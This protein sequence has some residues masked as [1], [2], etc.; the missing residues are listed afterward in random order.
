MAAITVE[1][2]YDHVEEF[3][4]L[5]AAAEL[6]ASTAWEITFTEDMRAKFQRFGPRTNLSAA[7]RQTLERIAKS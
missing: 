1:E 3:I 2:T 5:L 7:Q 6:H 4:A